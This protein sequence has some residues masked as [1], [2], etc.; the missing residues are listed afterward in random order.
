MVYV[1]PHGINES[2]QVGEGTRIWAFAH[3]LAGARIGAD[4]NIC[5]HVFIENDV[6]L[7][8]RVTVKSGVQLWDGIRVEDDVFIGPNASFVNDLMPRSKQ[9]LDVHPETRIGAG[10]SIGSGATILPVSIGRNAMIGAGAVVTRDVPANAIVI[11][12]PARISGYVGDEAPDTTPAARVAPPL[13]AGAGAQLLELTS[14]TDLRGSLVAAEFG[15]LPFAPARMFT[16]FDVPS[17]EVRGEHA[18]RR[19]EQFLVCVRGSVRCLVDDGAHRIEFVLDRPG[20]GLHIP[21]MRWGT[22]YHYSGDALL[23]VLA[24]LPYDPD[25]YIRSYEAFLRLVGET[26]TPLGA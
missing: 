1:H 8:D 20:V 17:T 6:V 12:N 19:C 18:H 23:V 2:D 14:A 16:V 9:W 13:T 22:Q 10:A 11:G 5:D 21:A 26:T 7:G 15:A 3:V 25:D 24:S 4:C